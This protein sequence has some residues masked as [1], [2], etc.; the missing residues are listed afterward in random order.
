[1]SLLKSTAIDRGTAGYDYYFGSGRVNAGAAVIAARQG[2]V[3]DGQPPAVSIAAPTGGT[4]SGTIPVAVNASDNVGVS[5]V[6]LLV[7]GA[8]LAS[9]AAAPYAFSWN[10]AGAAGSTV[11]LVARAYDAAGNTANSPA[12]SVIVQSS[13]STTSDTTPPTASI[14]NPGNGSKVNAMVNISATATDNVA[15]AS[16]TLYVDGVMVSSSNLPSASYKWNAKNAAKG[17]HTISAVARD[18]AG[19]QAT[20]TIQVTKSR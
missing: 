18:A 14:T 2:S 17:A 1:V 8:V 19:N 16:L 10:T 12:V 15:V 20:K 5:R 4:V 3:V 9:D 6:D 13:I 11:T 7:N